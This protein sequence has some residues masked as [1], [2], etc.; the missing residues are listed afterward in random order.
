MQIIGKKIIHLKNVNSTNHF[1]SDLIKNIKDSEGTVVVSENQ[2]S[3]RGRGSN[4]WASAKKKNLLFSIILYPEFLEIQQQFYLSKVM[5][6]GIT[7]FLANYSSEVSIKWPNDIY[8]GNK[9][10]CGTLIEQIVAGK[11]IKSSVVG[12]GL[13]INQVRFSKELRNP[14]S[15]K[16]VTGITYDLDEC[17]NNLLLH[18][19][20]RYKQLKEKDF[21]SIDLAYNSHL[22]QLG[23]QASYKSGKN[24]FAAVLKGVN[25]DGQLIL[26]DAEKNKKYFYMDEIVFIIN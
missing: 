7:D 16:K 15:L 19:D 26:V 14:V 20:N 8:I 10:I 13:N 12:I 6:L 3:G 4:Q 1:A 24:I 21:K 25:H 22:F 18:L 23:E 11:T 2:I 9:K 5:A 17:L